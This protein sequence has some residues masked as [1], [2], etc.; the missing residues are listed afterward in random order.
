LKAYR[1][2]QTFHV[3]PQIGYGWKAQPISDLL[4]LGKGVSEIFTK[5]MSTETRKRGLC[6]ELKIADWF[7]AS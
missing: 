6:A 1:S 4:E 2:D 7:N 5:T 3:A